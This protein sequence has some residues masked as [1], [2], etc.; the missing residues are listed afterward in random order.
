MPIALFAAA[1]AEQGVVKDELELQCILANLIYR[2]YLKGY[3]AYKAQVV[4]LA[5]TDPFPDL[6]TVQLSDPFTL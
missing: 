5:K 1:L 3:L 6:A 2:K 4:V